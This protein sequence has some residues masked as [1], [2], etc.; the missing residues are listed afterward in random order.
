MQDLFIEAILKESNSALFSR[1]QLTV[2]ETKYLWSL[3]RPES[4]VV[5]AYRGKFTCGL[6]GII[7]LSS[8]TAYHIE[9]GYLVEFLVELL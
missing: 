2:N 7:K 9:Y 3:L 8:D 4:L 5:N 1:S 6:L